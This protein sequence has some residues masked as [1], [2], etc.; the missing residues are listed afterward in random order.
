M[1]S[2]PFNRWKDGSATWLNAPAARPGRVHHADLAKIRF[3]QARQR[4]GSQPGRRAAADNRNALNAL[5]GNRAPK[6][7]VGPGG[8]AYCPAQRHDII[9]SYHPIYRIILLLVRR[10]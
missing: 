5:R 6:L 7:K 1:P 9:D 10:D 8:P 3:Q 4:R 2:S